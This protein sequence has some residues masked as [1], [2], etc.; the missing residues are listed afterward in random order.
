MNKTLHKLDGPYITRLDGV[1]VW[2]AN[3]LRIDSWDQLKHEGNLSDEEI[4]ALAI[5]WGDK[6][7]Q[8]FFPV[9]SKKNID[10]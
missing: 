10:L 1:G 2:Y 9:N 7:P 5:I 3:D 4:L 8:P 6:G